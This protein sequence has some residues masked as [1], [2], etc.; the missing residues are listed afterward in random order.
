MRGMGAFE[1]CEELDDEE[2]T[3]PYKCRSG[4]KICCTNSSIMKETFD[5]FGTCQKIV[6]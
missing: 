6:S 2:H 1:R 5:E 4:R 3:V